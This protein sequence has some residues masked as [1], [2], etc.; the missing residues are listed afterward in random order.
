M[1]D[2]DPRKTAVA[3][4]AH[5]D[6]AEIFCGGTLVR[7]RQLGWEIHIATGT[8]GDC[9]TM[10]L[11]AGEISQVRRGEAIAAAGMLGGHYHCLE[12]LDGRVC[13]S[14]ST[15][16]KAVDLFR[17]I[18]PQ[19][20]IT[21]PRHDYMLDHEQIH[22]IARMASFLFAAPNASSLLAAPAGARVPY[23]YYCSPLGE[24]EQDIVPRSRTLVD[25]TA[26]Y[27]DKMRLLA[28]HASQR[29]WLRAH[30]GMDEYLEAVRRQDA[31]TG[32][33][34][35]TQYAEAFTQHTGH[36]YPSDNLLANHLS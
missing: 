5:P 6:D 20:V 26:V 13:Y 28:C 2:S 15:I 23:L 29:E 34:L 10:T 25:V 33:L 9:G 8:A 14:P 1:D 30:H 12:E 11:S 22:L 36:A 35:G 17:E 27:S 24:M 19:L 4:L 16:Q 18:N 31:E 21:H 32:K 3:L 7:L